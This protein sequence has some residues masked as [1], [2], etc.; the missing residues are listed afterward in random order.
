MLNFTIHTTTEVVFGRD[1]EKDIGPKLK[2]IGAHR[3][4]VHFGGSS[5]RSSGLLD[6][7]EHSL[8]EAGLSFVELGGVEPNPKISMV[9]RGIELCQREGIDFILAVGGGSVLD[10]AKGIGMGVATGRDPW[11]FA[12]TGTAPDQTL[13]VGSVLTL[14]ASGSETSNS[15]VLTN[16]EL[17][18]KRGIT[19]QTNRPR[20][21]FLNPENTFTVSK[22]QTGCGIVDIMMHTL[23]RYLTAG[24]ETDI[25]DRIAEGLLIATRDAGR[26]AIA[27]PNDYEARA[28]LM[29]AGSISHNNLTECGRLRLFPVHKLEHELSAFRDEIAHGAGLSVLFPAWALYVMEHDV[30]RFAQLAHRVLGV[31]MDFS[32]PERTARDGILTLKRFFEEIGMP[33]HMAQ[34]GIKPEN[35]ETL[36]DNAIRTAG[37][38]VK[39]YVP[40]DKPAIL[41][42]FRLAE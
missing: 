21:S 27:D 19:S 25:T 40:L 33:V 10:S 8:F 32:H 39:S 29:W 11:E 24:G 2:E 30:P 34:L 4:L 9:R 37:G 23:E 1:I 12:A 22:F 3:V 5:A 6:R 35:Y 41:E 13:P 38:P 18:E 20:I 42:I 36:A 26:R 28:T 17:K 16:E 31:E 7:V 14:S 15:C